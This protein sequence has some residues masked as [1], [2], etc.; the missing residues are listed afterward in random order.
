MVSD[1]NPPPPGD[2]PDGRPDDHVEDDIRV[3]ERDEH[4]VERDEQRLDDDRERVDD[5]IERLERDLHRP[6]QFTVNKKPVTL[7]HR[8]A[9]GLEIKQAAIN[10]HVEIQLSFQLWRENGHGDHDDEQIAD[11]KT[12]TVHDGDAFDAND[13]DD[14]S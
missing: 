6:V 2:R 1:H 12:I 7:D 11:D 10:A 3:L 5:D 4:R 8:R 9:T 13:D 14:N